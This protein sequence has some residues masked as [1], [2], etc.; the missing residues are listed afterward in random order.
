[1]S[2]HWGY[3]A[4]LCSAFLFGIST[5]VN[6]ILLE[7]VSPFM[8]AS[9]TYIIAGLFLGT[10]NLLP[11]KASLVSRLKLPNS[12]RTEP[13]RKDNILLLLSALVGGVLG[14]SLYLTGLNRTTAVSTALLGNTETLFTIAIAF[15]FLRERGRPKDYVAIALLIIG[16]VTL[17]T[18]LNFQDLHTLGMF[19]GNILVVL[20]AFCW[21]IDNILARI[22]TLRRS[23]L[24]LGS[25]KEIIG[26]GV[27]FAF[28]SLYGI[29]PNLTAFS[30]TWLAILGVFS[31]G[32]SLLLFLFSLQQIGA[33][34]TGVAFSMASLFGA[35]TAFIVLRESIS[36]V[37]VL[38]G[39]V[40]FLGI[41]VLSIPKK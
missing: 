3:V 6:K 34:R 11:K 27:L 4:I 16:A 30:I 37:Q 19:L 39:C 10:V 5:T 35:A 7:S 28:A 13:T 22:L 38:A 8:I 18:N 33:M 14:P 40:M 29:R 20:G 26:G 2:H 23:L 17:T 36:L 1:M 24:Q 32:L 15:I 25:L 41:Y 12:T 21:A 9:M 31:I